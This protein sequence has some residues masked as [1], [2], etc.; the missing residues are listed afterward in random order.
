MNI[1][2][3][4]DSTII[5]WNEELRPHVKEVFQHLKEEGHKIYVWSGVGIRWDVIE[6]HGLKPF[7]T[8]CFVKPTFNYRESLTSLGVDVHPDFCIDDHEELTRAL[9]GMPVKPYFLSD[10]ND[11]EMLRVYETI[12]NHRKL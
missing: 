4:V 6:R 1:F 12:R 10:V 5:S 2:F 9:G 8:K 3:D 7:V 11:R